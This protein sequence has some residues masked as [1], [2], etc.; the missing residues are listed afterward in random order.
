MNRRNFIKWGLRAGTGAWL[1][2]SGIGCSRDSRNRNAPL[3]L[4]PLPYPP[5]SLAPYISSQTVELHYG[6]HHRHYVARA[7]QLII[8]DGLDRLPPEAIMRRTYR[9]G[10]C[11][12][13]PLFNN[14]AQVYNYVFYWNSMRSGGG[15]RPPAALEAT[16]ADAFGDFDHFCTAFHAKARERFASGW[17]WLVLANNRMEIV[18]TPYAENPLLYGQRPLL[19]LDVW[20]H[21]YYIDYQYRREDYVQAFLDHLV[22]WRFA[23]A[24]LGDV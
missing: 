4:T 2:M 23:A 7:N 13:S 19:V 5:D 15:G 21:A 8:A 1:T 16:L 3:K 14:T 12:Q 18:G 11:D 24:N 6:R 9:E 17:I 22:N 20:E 10:Q